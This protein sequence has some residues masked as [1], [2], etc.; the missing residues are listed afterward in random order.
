M[1]TLLLAK[2]LIETQT[3]GNASQFLATVTGDMKANR[4]W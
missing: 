1:L 3:P 2:E 4:N